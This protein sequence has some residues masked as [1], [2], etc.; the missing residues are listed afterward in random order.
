[1][2]VGKEKNAKIITVQ[3]DEKMFVI[4]RRSEQLSGRKGVMVRREVAD[5]GDVDGVVNK[6][7]EGYQGP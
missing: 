1:M 4:V 3:V 7:K 2:T 6:N 5:A